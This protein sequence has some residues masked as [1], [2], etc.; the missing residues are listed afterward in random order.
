MGKK[1]IKTYKGFDSDLKCRGFK[2]E[3][4]KTYTMP[5]GETPELCRR[6]FHAISDEQ[7]PLSVFDFYPPAVSGKPSRYCEVELSGDV[8]HDEEKYAGS[9]IKVGAEIGIPGIIKAHFD[10]VKKRI[11]NENNAKKGKAATAGSCGAATAG[12]YGAAT[13]GDSGAATAGSY[14]AATA[15]SCGAATAGDSGAATAGDRGAA[16]SRGKT[17]VG[18]NGL[19]VARG[20]GVMV[21]GG[22][23]AVLVIA[24]E[25]NDNY[26]I[27]E[28]KA[29]VVDGKK[30][31]A[32]TWYK[33][34]D[35]ELK[36]VED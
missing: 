30:V 16:T 7:S 12:S 32:D 1:T 3:I 22:L 31:K 36:E 19:A 6:G 35:G 11:T 21:K 17:A 23:G 33:L 15:G 9:E 25:N 8:E 28:W 4:G 2:Y 26:D 29:V 5:E 24:V 14:G 13:A 10:W 20:S 27:K 18:K 34:V